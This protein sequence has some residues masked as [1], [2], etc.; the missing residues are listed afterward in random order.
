[1]Q[2]KDGKSSKKFCS[3]KMKIIFLGVRH[4]H[5]FFFF[6]KCIDRKGKPRGRKGGEWR[7]TWCRSDHA[8][9]V[10]VGQVTPA[11]QHRNPRDPE[12]RL[13]ALGFHG[14]RDRRARDQG[15]PATM[16]NRAGASGSFQGMCG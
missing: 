5:D 12:P 8:Q 16:S 2:L 6:F 11:G 13:R 1:M 7:R 14:V 9:N 3:K 4:S 15:P 10:H